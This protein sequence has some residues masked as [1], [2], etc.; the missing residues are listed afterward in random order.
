[1]ICCDKCKAEISP[2]VA[3]DR[4]DSKRMVMAEFEFNLRAYNDFGDGV[5]IERI[6]PQAA[7]LC[8]SCQ[9]VLK[10]NLITTL[11]KFLGE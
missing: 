7:C 10:E 6:G 8:E 5:K 2:D 9:N 1:V 3:D 11:K 4:W